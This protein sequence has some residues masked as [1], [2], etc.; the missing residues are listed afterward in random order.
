MLQKNIYLDRIMIRRE[1]LG[2]RDYRTLINVCIRLGLDE[3]KKKKGIMFK[4]LDSNGNIVSLVIHIHADGRDI[5]KGIFIRY[6][7][8]LGFKSI[9]DYEDFIK[10]KKRRR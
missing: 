8:E 1:I 6:I 3:I 7:K 2:N 4:G 10:N 9:D 5:P